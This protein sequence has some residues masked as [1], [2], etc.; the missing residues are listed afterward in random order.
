MRIFL[1]IFII[2]SFIK[3]NAE[4]LSGSFLE[5]GRQL[6]ELLEVERVPRDIIP[7]IIPEIVDT[8]TCGFSKQI[9]KLKSYEEMV[10]DFSEYKIPTTSELENNIMNMNDILD[11]RRRLSESPYHRRLSESSYDI[12]KINSWYKTSNI[13]NDHYDKFEQVVSELSVSHNKFDIDT[14]VQGCVRTVDDGIIAAPIILVIEDSN[15]RLIDL[16]KDVYLFKAKNDLKKLYTDRDNIMSTNIYCQE[17]KP[18]SKMNA[19]YIIYDYETQLYDEGIELQNAIRPSNE[20]LSNQHYSTTNFRFVLDIPETDY[21]YNS[22]G[23]GGAFEFPNLNGRP[24][25]AMADGSYPQRYECRKD[26]DCSP[27]WNNDVYCEPINNKCKFTTKFKAIFMTIR[28]K[29]LHSKEYSLK[30]Y[31]LEGSAEYEH[32]INVEFIEFIENTNLM[33][34]LFLPGDNNISTVYDNV[35]KT[36]I[37]ENKNFNE[38]LKGIMSNPSIRKMEA[39]E[40][41]NILAKSMVYEMKNINRK[42]NGLLHSFEKK[43]TNFQCP[44]GKKVSYDTHCSWDGSKYVCNEDICCH[45]VNFEKGI[46]ENNLCTRENVNYEYCF[47]NKNQVKSIAKFVLYIDKD[48]VGVQANRI[49]EKNFDKIW[50]SFEYVGN[51]ESINIRFITMF[52]QSLLTDASGS[53]NLDYYI[54]DKWNP[55]ADYSNTK[56]LKRGKRKFL[57]SIKKNVHRLHKKYKGM[58]SNSYTDGGFL[59][60]GTL[61]RDDSLRI[62]EEIKWE[63]S[64]EFQNNLMPLINHV[65]SP[66]EKPLGESIVELLKKKQTVETELTNME[67][68]IQ[69]YSEK[70]DYNETIKLRQDLE[71]LIQRLINDPYFS[72]LQNLLQIDLEAIDIRLSADQRLSNITTSISQQLRKVTRRLRKNKE[73]TLNTIGKKLEKDIKKLGRRLNQLLV[74]MNVTSIRNLLSNSKQL[75]ERLNTDDNVT[76]IVISIEKQLGLLISDHD[77][78][79]IINTLNGLIYHLINT[80]DEIS[81]LIVFLGDTL[82]RLLSGFNVTSDISDPLQ[83]LSQLINNNNISNIRNMI[84]IAFRGLVSGYS[85][86]SEILGSLETSLVK[87]ITR[88]NINI[89]RIVANSLGPFNNVAEQ[90]IGSAAMLAYDFMASTGTGIISQANVLALGVAEGFSALPAELGTYVQQNVLQR[91]INRLIISFQDIHNIL[92]NVIRRKQDFN[93]YVDNTHTKC[94]DYKENWFLKL[95]QELLI[96]NNFEYDKNINDLYRFERSVGFLKKSE[97]DFNELMKKVGTKLKHNH[98][99]KL[100]NRKKNKLLGFAHTKFCKPIRYISTVSKEFYDTCSKLKEIASYQPMINDFYEKYHKLNK[101]RLQVSAM[102]NQIINI[103]PYN[104]NIIPYNS[105]DSLLQE[106]TYLNSLNNYL[107]LMSRKMKRYSHIYDKLE[108]KTQD[109]EDQIIKPYKKIFMKKRNQQNSGGPGRLSGPEYAAVSSSESSA[110]SYIS[111]SGNKIDISK[112]DLLEINVVSNIRLNMVRPDIDLPNNFL[113]IKKDINNIVNFNKEFTNIYD[114]EGRLMNPYVRNILYQKK[115]LYGP[116]HLL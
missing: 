41:A 79:N 64:T 85:G 12:E 21:T 68:D 53:V 74:E 47:L 61:N 17:F 71:N 104:I 34:T 83:F 18:L 69:D 75:V 115:W 98:V 8:K 58:L 20:E 93:G 3:T 54:W 15:G 91:M 38:H 87:L 97:N 9:Q 94:K 92:E 45:S 5:A 13:P 78:S 108:S 43:C 102:T 28:G 22:L 7:E 76:G 82:Q 101:L 49:I 72:N 111:D 32:I 25:V 77:I 31:V 42:M 60:V 67:K 11:N 1:Y 88:D 63:L 107:V 37:K 66:S 103:L 4:F 95:Q 6:D 81:M 105:K 59:T 39:L 62:G 23:V 30:P 57:D 80:Y 36:N 116:Y 112:K 50:K 113:E 55:S 27:N 89:R 14:I 90:V 40:N 70:F 29:I 35:W 48:I 73:D 96:N 51:D 106:F 16:P 44:I 114:H 100:S 33:T 65:I 109:L 26:A 84:K 110:S 56:V 46:L 10:T 24:W 19:R 86:V 99:H 52:L 2:L